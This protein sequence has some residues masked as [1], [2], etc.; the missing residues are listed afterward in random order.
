M[1]SVEMWPGRWWEGA[2]LAVLYGKGSPCR[3]TTRVKALRR[4][5]ARLMERA[6]QRPVWL[7]GVSDVEVGAGAGEEGGA[8][9]CRA[10]VFTPDVTGSPAELAG[11]PAVGS[12][13]ERALCC[14]PR[15]GAVGRDEVTLPVPWG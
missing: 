5:R 11:Q 2:S 14:W 8:R 9:A 13:L 15:G 6:E 7:G 12:V 10:S 4:P 1:D 3:G